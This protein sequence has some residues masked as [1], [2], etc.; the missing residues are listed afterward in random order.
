MNTRPLFGPLLTLALVVVVACSNDN[1]AAPGGGG[2]VVP[3]DLVSIPAGSFTMGSPL[4]EPGRAE[5]ENAHRVT[6][7]HEFWMKSHEVTNEEYRQ[8]AN[9]AMAEGLI[10]I[11]GD[12]IKVLRDVGNGKNF[13]LSLTASGSELDYDA[14]GDSLIIYDVGFGL[15]PDHPIKYLTWWGAAAYCNWRSIR[16]GREPAYDQTTWAVDLYGATG[17]RLPTEAEWEY[18]AR[19]GNETAFGGSQ[20]MEIGCEVDSLQYQGWYCFNAEEWSNSVGTKA[21]NAY[22]LYDMHGNVWEFCN[23]WYGEFYYT[24]SPDTN[25]AGPPAGPWLRSARGGSWGWGAK[26]ARAASRGAHFLG[27]VSPRE[28]VRPVL[29]HP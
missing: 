19:G 23:D 16:E 7:T 4:N 6:L 18:A 22:G 14:E 3:T 1:P 15:N 10:E 24:A 5:N 8:A 13:F 26:Y 25:P 11:T 2:D 27:M 20:I 21:P 29:V 9:W 12:E 28:S 17:Y